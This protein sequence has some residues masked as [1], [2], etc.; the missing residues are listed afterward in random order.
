VNLLMHLTI[1]DTGTEMLTIRYPQFAYE[2]IHIMIPYEII[3][4]LVV[5]AVV[6]GGYLSYKFATRVKAKADATVQK[7]AN[8]V[9]KL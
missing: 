2:E 5:L 8:E 9:K 4:I 6:A 3:V 7:V 1:Y